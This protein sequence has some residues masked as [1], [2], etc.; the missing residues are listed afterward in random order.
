MTRPT[1][2][3]RCRQRPERARARRPAGTLLPRLLLLAVL[4]ATSPPPA[5]APAV[6]Q[7]RAIL[8]GV[9]PGAPRAA[10]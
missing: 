10:V 4:A 9:A 2:S 1:A 6:A 7:A 3:R 8:H 5:A